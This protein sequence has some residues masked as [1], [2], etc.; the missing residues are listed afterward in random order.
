[1]VI[2][3]VN[4]NI[5]TLD[6]RSGLLRLGWFIF[7]NVPPTASIVSAILL[8]VVPSSTLLTA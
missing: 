8:P 6:A 5:V 2:F 3:V 7:T 1:M 4:G